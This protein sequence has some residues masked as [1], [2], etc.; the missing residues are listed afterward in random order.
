MTRTSQR[1][2]VAALALLAAPAVSAAQATPA[3]REAA[4]PSMLVPASW[5]AEHLR[6]PGL[7]VVHVAHARQ[8]A[9]FDSAH[10]PGARLLPYDRIAGDVDSVAVELPTAER[11][12]DAF[13]ALGVGDD[14][15]VVLVGDPMSA[16]R[17]WMTLDWLGMGERAALLDGGLA[18]WRAGGHPLSR[19]REAAPAPGRLTARPRPD[20]VVDAAWVRARLADPRVAL[21]DAR[22][23]DEYTG[24][25][26]GHRHMLAGHIPGARNLY[27][28]RLIVSPQDPRFRP[29]SELRALFE[30]A[31]AAPDRIVLTYCMVGMRASVTYFV[32]RLLGYDTRF[33]DGSWDDWSRRGLPAVRGA[34]PGTPDAR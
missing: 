3:A 30:Q 15:R 9:A 14:S 16:A 1:R 6:D 12:R 28:E 8:A 29:A 32:S 2:L 25:D 34:E 27:W 7:V 4:L 19:E 17:A 33:Y 18:A 24:A 20:R 26:G 21:V 10:V 23:A 22:P 11:V 13:A 31:G 5:L